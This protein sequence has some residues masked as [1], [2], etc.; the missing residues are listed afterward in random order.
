M[1]P[2]A[3]GRTPAPR[4]GADDPR[5]P[6]NNP[7]NFPFGTVALS[8]GETLEESI[9]IPFEQ[10]TQLP[11]SPVVLLSNTFG[12]GTGLTPL[13]AYL[14]RINGTSDVFYN[15][16]TADRKAAKFFSEFFYTQ[17]A[18]GLAPGDA[19]RQALLNLIRTSEV[20]HPFSW[21]QFFHYGI[22]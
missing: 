17:L 12:Q 21:G 18:N 3:P 6:R 10:L 4:R 22:G 8:D 14:L 7:G 1:R 2:D 15:A 9:D 19:Y 13:H 20:N 16:W 5:C 11:A